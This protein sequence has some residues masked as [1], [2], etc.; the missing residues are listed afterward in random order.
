VSKKKWRHIDKTRT[1]EFVLVSKFIPC[2]QTAFKKTF[3][4]NIFMM[5]VYEE[6]D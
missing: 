2:Y 4:T 5:N 6:E 3:Y 1:D